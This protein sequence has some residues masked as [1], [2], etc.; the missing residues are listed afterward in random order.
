MSHAY[1][2]NQASFLYAQTVRCFL[3]LHSQYSSIHFYSTI[4]LGQPTRIYSGAVVSH[5]MFFFFPPNILFQ[6]NC[7][8]GLKRVATDATNKISWKPYRRVKV[9]FPILQYGARL[10]NH[11]AS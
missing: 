4:V 3:G 10:V 6:L 5:Y 7:N 11:L 9:D 1:K 2:Q 8:S